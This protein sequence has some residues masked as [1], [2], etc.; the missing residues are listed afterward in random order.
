MVVGHELCS[1]VVRSH[2]HRRN[3][4][5]CR[6]L[7]SLQSFRTAVWLHFGAFW[8]RLWYP[9]FNYFYLL[10]IYLCL[11]FAIELAF[12]IIFLSEERNRVYYWYC[13]TGRCICLNAC[14]KT[15]DAKVNIIL[16]IYLYKGRF[17]IN[18]LF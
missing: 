17:T 6:Y 14:H 18:F 5:L 16:Y 10:F 7:R 3:L 11:F 2:V 13:S 4:A 1:V 12:V 9:F 15:Q 8:S